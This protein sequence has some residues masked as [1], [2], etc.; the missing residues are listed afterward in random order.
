MGVDQPCENKA[1]KVERCIPPGARRSHWEGQACGQGP[2]VCAGFRCIG[3]NKAP[4]KGTGEAEHG[5][6]Q[7]KEGSGGPRGEPRVTWP[8]E[9]NA[10]R[11][12]SVSHPAN[13]TFIL[14]ISVS[15]L[16]FINASTFGCSSTF[17]PLQPLR[18][19]KVYVRSH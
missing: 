18:F 19:F 16:G 8:D 11:H 9:F 12:A 3:R 5:R 15:H 17:L 10:E 1:Q 13:Q 14:T 4:G 2:E 7:E 6:G